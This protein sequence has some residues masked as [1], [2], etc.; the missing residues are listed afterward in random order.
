MSTLRVLFNAPPDANREADW[1]LFDATG[2]VARSGRGPRADWPQAD[3]AEAVL[4]AT[5]GRLVTLA[6]PPLPAARALAA[7]KFA[8]EDQLA[9]APDESHVAVAAQAPTGALRAAIVASSWLREFVAASTRAGMRWGRIVLESD[10]ALA[11]ADGWCWCASALD[12]PGFVRTADGTTIAV[13][14]AQADAPPGELLLALAGSRKPRPRTVRVDVA[15]ATPAL[16]ARWRETTGVEFI[17]GTPWR[18]TAAAPAAFTAAIDLQTGAFAVAPLAPRVD[19]LRVLRPALWIAALA[20]GIH[21][22]ASVGQW[23]S[24]QWQAA[25]LQRDIA[26]LA[27]TAAPEEAA[28]APPATAIARRD[29]SVRHRAGLV[30]GDDLLPLLARAAPALATLPA[31][32]IRSLRYADGHVVF[33]LQKLD[34][35]QPARVQHELQ[36]LGLVAIAAPNANGTRLRVGLD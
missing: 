6:L 15:G 28:S 35:T 22:L 34:A 13:G 2:R 11:P 29:A 14:L 8:L 5:H 9:G 21:V 3:A 18:W 30:A 27:S 36:Q 1:A 32:A 16:L 31:G 23:L 24:L 12:R 20:I 25:Q 26:T 19:A 10:L 33:E 7:A 4:A 17:A